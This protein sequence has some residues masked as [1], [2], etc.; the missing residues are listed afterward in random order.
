MGINKTNEINYLKRL[1][2]HFDKMHEETRGDL[3]E[4]FKNL[5]TKY[6]S[7]INEIS[8]KTSKKLR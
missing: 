6:K 5:S 4:Y 7:K 8:K 3:K 1:K 2:Q